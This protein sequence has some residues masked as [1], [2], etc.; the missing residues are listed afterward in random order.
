MRRRMESLSIAGA[1]PTERHDA[2]GWQQLGD[3]GQLHPCECPGSWRYDGVG[4]RFITRGEWVH[5]WHCSRCADRWR[6][7]ARLTFWQ[8][9]VRW[10]EQRN[11]P[12]EVWQYRVARWPFFWRLCWWLHAAGFIVSPPWHSEVPHLTWRDWMWTWRPRPGIPP[13]WYVQLVGRYTVWLFRRRGEQPVLPGLLR[14]K[15]EASA[16]ARR[17]RERWLQGQASRWRP[18]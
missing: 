8:R 11:E 13:W 4:M 10:Y 1:P 5:R 6:A 16:M 7:P 9:F 17:R 2:S 15:W 14:L 18:T 12:S 3:D